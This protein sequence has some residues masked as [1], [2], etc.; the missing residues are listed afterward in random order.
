MPGMEPNRFGFAQLGRIA[1]LLTF[2]FVRVSVYL[3]K[4]YL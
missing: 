4:R 2:G 3:V 1:K